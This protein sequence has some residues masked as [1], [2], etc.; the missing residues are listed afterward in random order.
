MPQGSV[1]DTL[2]FLMYVNDIWRNIDSNIRLFANDCII[3]RKVINKKERKAAE[4]S[5]H[6]GGMGRRKWDENKHGKIKATRITR[7]SVK[8]HWVSPLVTKKFRKRAVVNFW[9]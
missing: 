9:E 4:G 6:L 3:Y 1:L 5:V 8:I 2:Q 7:A